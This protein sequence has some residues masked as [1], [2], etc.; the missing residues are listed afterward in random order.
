MGILPHRPVI[1]D[2]F[3]ALGFAQPS[4]KDDIIKGV[5]EEVYC[6]SISSQLPDNFSLLLDLRY[7][8][9][10]GR[11]HMLWKCCGAYAPHLS[12]PFATGR[13]EVHHREHIFM[14]NT[15]CATGF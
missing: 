7:C 5:V 9:T 6:V 11:H 14:C 12:F 3:P 15:A 13:M 10:L 2:E 8:E 1:S 4:L